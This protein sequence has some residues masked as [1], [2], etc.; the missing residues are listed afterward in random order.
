M[1][2]SGKKLEVGVFALS[3]S[4][5]YYDKAMEYTGGSE[6]QMRNIVDCLSLLRSKV[7]VFISNNNSPIQY[8]KDIN[9]IIF[10]Y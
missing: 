10:H 3:S 8:Y 4:S 5:Y 6:R 9:I 1:N 2:L 7:D